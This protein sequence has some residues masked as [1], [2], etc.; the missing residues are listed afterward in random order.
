MF[1]SGF[2]VRSFF[3]GLFFLNELLHLFIQAVFFMFLPYA[4]V[5]AG[6]GFNFKLLDA[7][8]A[9]A[10]HLLGQRLILRLGQLGG[11]QMEVMD[12]LAQPTA[13]DFRPTCTDV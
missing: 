2:E 12:G 8:A 5:L 6:M 1:T 7:G 13:S 9:G 11:R 4:T 3:P 10:Y